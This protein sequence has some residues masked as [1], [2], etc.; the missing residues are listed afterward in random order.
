MAFPNEFLHYT[1]LQVGISNNPALQQRIPKIADVLS[2]QGF[3]DYS[4]SQTA[5]VRFSQRNAQQE[6]SQVHQFANET[7]TECLSFGT[8]ILSF[9]ISKDATVLDF[10][11]VL[12]KFKLLV[13]DLTDHLDCLKANSRSTRFVFS[14]PITNLPTSKIAPEFQ[15]IGWENAEHIHGSFEFWEDVDSDF[16]GRRTLRVKTTKRHST[17]ADDLNAIK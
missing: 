17:E 12:Q 10:D 15:G 6:V 1:V 16:S 9:V 5:T 8:S 11:S 4:L 13:E 7:K 2:N 14:V 3:R